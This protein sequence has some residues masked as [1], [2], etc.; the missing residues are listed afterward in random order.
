MTKNKQIIE[1]PYLGKEYSVSFELFMNKMPTANYQSVIQLTTGKDCCGMG[2]RS[3]GVWV[4]NS[5]ELLVTAAISG[6]GNTHKMFPGMEENKWYK[7]E[8][9]QRKG[10]GKVVNTDFE[11]SASQLF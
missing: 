6:N 3:P 1:L 2:D 9:N 11:F 7:I 10:N 5:K 4:M 8:I